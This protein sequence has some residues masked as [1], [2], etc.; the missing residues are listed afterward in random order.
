MSAPFGS[1]RI[2]ARFMDRDA[3]AVDVL[4]D[5]THALEVARG[6]AFAID[7]DSEITARW[8]NYRDG[9]AALSVAVMEAMDRLG[10]ASEPER[11][12]TACYCDSVFHP[13]GCM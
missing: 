2:V 7:P 4:S 6:A 8:T 10:T 11:K 12:R 3:D 13:E 9:F 5:L 1:A